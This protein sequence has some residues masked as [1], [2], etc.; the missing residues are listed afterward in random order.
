LKSVGC[1]AFKGCS[2]LKTLNL[3]NLTSI[4]SCGFAEC[5]SIT[6][7]DLPNLVLVEQFA[8]RGCTS[9]QFIYLPKMI[10]KGFNAF[11]SCPISSFDKCNQ[12]RIESSSNSYIKNRN[13]QNIKHSFGEPTDEELDE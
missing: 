6:K 1:N 5:T 10:Y 11:E 7:L 3:P 2:S 12:K 13:E 8:F 9:L 4:S